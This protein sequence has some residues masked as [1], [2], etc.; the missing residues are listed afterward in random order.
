MDAHNATI[1]IADDHVPSR[2]VIRHLLTRCNH[3]VIMEADNG[4]KLLKQLEMAPVLPDICLLDINMPEMNGFDTAR[5]L[6]QKWPS[7]KI[8]AISGDHL[9]NLIK[10]EKMGADGFIQKNCTPVELNE[11]VLKLLKK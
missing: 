6:K 1:A 8:L 11:A 7:I 2:K 9:Y 3:T 4:K 10:I 5:L